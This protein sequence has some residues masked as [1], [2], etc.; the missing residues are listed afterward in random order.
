MGDVS[1]AEGA[2]GSSISNA[3]AMVLDT[4][5][6]R[7]GRGE[8]SREDATTSYGEKPS[9]QEKIAKLPSLQPFTDNSGG[10]RGGVW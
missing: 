10:G 2:E 8:G 6:Q 5:N 4:E 9:F 3:F 7:E 1:G